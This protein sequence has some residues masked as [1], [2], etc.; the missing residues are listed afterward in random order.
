MIAQKPASF[1]SPVHYLRREKPI[2]ARRARLER[3]PQKLKDALQVID[4]ARF[5]AARMILCERKAR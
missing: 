4:L 3:I 1:S 5:L 2:P